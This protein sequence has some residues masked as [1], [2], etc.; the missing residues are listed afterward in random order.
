LLQH[1]GHQFHARELA[2]L[3]SR[4]PSASGAL[5]RHEA[6]QI[7]TDLGDAGPGL[8][9]RART[10]YQARLGELRAGID[11][12]ERDNDLG[13]VEKLRAEADALSAVIIREAGFRGRERKQSSHSER[14]RV[15]ITRSI[16]R[17]IEKIRELN[18]VLGRH[19]ANSIRTGYFCSYAPDQASQVT[20]RF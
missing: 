5:D 2:A 4:L 6:D 3:D 18:P 9:A 10:E 8:D 1:P 13:R 14:A 16:H 19:L 17:G 20:W 11:E 15:A 7:S 12:A